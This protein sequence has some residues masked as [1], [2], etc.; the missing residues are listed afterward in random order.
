MN[1][2]NKYYIRKTFL[3]SGNITQNEKQSQSPFP[4]QVTSTHYVSQNSSW[5]TLHNHQ[6]C[7]W[8]P[9]SAY[10]L[11]PS[12]H[13]KPGLSGLV[14]LNLNHFSPISL[15]P[16]LKQIWTVIHCYHQTT[17][18]FTQLLTMLVLCIPAKKISC[19][20]ITCVLHSSVPW[21]TQPGLMQMITLFK[22][23]QICEH[24]CNI[25]GFA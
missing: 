3:L 6:T 11:A 9:S 24:V 18:P 7:L 19:L 15:P 13:A 2:M 22:Q 5:L 25:T 23:P 20:D 12:T 21:Q 4:S 10:K 17:Y 14:I 16:S 8:L 1:K